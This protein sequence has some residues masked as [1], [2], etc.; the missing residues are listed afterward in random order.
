MPI[1]EIGL[2]SFRNH[3]EIKLKFCPNINVIWGKNG[4]GKTAILEA[5][6]TL[7]IGR[8]FRTNGK[9]DLLKEGEEFF[10]II[11]KF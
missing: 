8:S 6:H 3:D 7:S 9:A 1:K 2:I 11:G 5:I 4:S 10:S